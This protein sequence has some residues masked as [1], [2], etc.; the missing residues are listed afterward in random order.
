MRRVDHSLII[1][2]TVTELYPNK[3]TT[4]D[5]RAKA[6]SK[7]DS[8][9]YVP[10]PWVPMTPDDQAD[11]DLEQRWREQV[12][13]NENE[14]DEDDDEIEYHPSNKAKSRINCLM[15]C[16]RSSMYPDGHEDRRSSYFV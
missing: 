14:D 12:E 5:K 8:I 7:S 16:Y 9:C 2:W 6:K 13:Y 11:T 4:F 10:I 15:L 1:G 3:I